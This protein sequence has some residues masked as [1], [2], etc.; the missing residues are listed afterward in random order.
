MC[1]STHVD[2]CFPFSLF[3]RVGPEQIPN[4]EGLLASYFEESTLH[5][6]ITCDLWQSPNTHTI[7]GVTGHFVNEKY[8]LKEVLLAARELP[9]DHTGKNMANHLLKV[10]EEYSLTSKVFCITAD[11]A[12]SNKTM[13]RH[14]EGFLPGF[15]E[16]QNLLGCVAHVLNLGARAALQILGN[17]TREEDVRQS[18]VTI[19]SLVTPL[20]PPE[21]AVSKIQKLGNMVHNS[22]QKME[23]F[24]D[25]VQ[26][27]N[28]KVKLTL[29][30][31][32][33]TRWNS[34]F[35][36]LQRA[37][38][39]RIP[40]DTFIHGNNLS[41]FQISNEEYESIGSVVKILKPLDSATKLLLSSKYPSISKVWS[42][43]T[44]LLKTLSK[45]KLDYEF[46][47]LKAPI[48]ALEKNC[49][50]IL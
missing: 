37:L 30:Q 24:A 39:L 14:L 18:S 38:I 7:L 47:R 45:Q 4:E 10:L 33:S 9:G 19:D 46:Q 36:M 42:I 48:E 5:V 25:H 41:E 20:A 40:I 8:E 44:Q 12:S 43:Y 11:N 6:S 32:V 17:E 27:F 31:D 21:S 22:A 35:S 1:N 16:N 13:A 26:L 23:N 15:L 50:P 49:C 29:A 2:P 3:L 28:P 34:T